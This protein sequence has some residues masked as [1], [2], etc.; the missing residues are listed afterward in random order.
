MKQRRVVITGIGTI[1]PL[2]HNVE[3]YFAALEGGVCGV[4][5]IKGFDASNNKTK[6]AAE[7]KNYNPEDYFERKEA[8]KLDAFT[9]YALIS[10]DEAIRDARLEECELNKNRVGVIW[11]AGIG[12]INAIS[13]ELSSY[14]KS[15]SGMPR[16]S[17][18]LVLKMLPNMAAGHISLKYGYKGPS[19]STVSACSS[20][21]HSIVSAVDQIR[22]GRADVVVT[23]GSEGAVS[24]VGIGSFNSM[25]A[26]STRND[27][28]KTASRPYDKS[29]DGFVMGEGG[30]A[31]VIEELEHA[32]T[33]GA[34]IYG[35][36]VGCGVSSD[37]Y[38]VT[39]PE[40][41]GEG[42]AYCMTMALEDAGIAPESIDYINT[43]GTSTPLGDIAELKGIAKVF[44][45]HIYKMN[46]SSTKSMTGHLLGA[47][48]AIEVL[49]ALLAVTRD[50]VPP[51]INI[52]ELD[53][54]IDPRINLTRDVAQHRTV[55]YALS[56]TFGFGGQNST[57]I[58]KKYRAE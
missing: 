28:P 26:L 34:K 21:T 55:E 5:F 9:Q 31:V 18:F 45:D 54:A 16:F 37:A 29:R 35:E 41:E 48:G 2:G 40:P 15:E 47:A 13:E 11:G 44:G 56:N 50:V 42:A 23:G 14:C 6:F 38:H 32:L 7:I 19:F 12:G 39:A 46:I 10:A 8:R 27:D 58:I 25:M 36:I 24:V 20:S 3:E 17:P 51:T 1:N 53:P 52:E 30:G 33:R 43:H 22:L 57:V 49:A 4:D